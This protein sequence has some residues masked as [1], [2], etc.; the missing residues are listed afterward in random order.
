MRENF[1]V[2][3]SPQ[4]GEA[5]IAEVVDTLR[6]GWI[7]TG[8]RVAQFEEAF[9]RYIGTEHAIAVSSCT[10]GLHLSMI[11]AGLAADDEVITTPMT[12]V[13]TANAIVHTGA[14]PVFV[15][16]DR[17]T[18]LI[19]PQ[20]I[21]DA[22]TPRTRAIVPV[23]LHGRPCD[24]DA[25]TEIAE[26]HGLIVIEDA[27]HAIESVH[28]GRK[29]GT[30]GRLTCFSFYATKNMTT[31]EGG[32]VTTND[33]DLADRIK[34]YALH[35]MSRD[36]WRRF[37]DAGYRHYQVGVPGFKYNMTDLQAAIGIHQLP[38]LDAW[39][40]R[41]NRIWQWYN[42]AFGEL[43]VGLPAPDEPDVVHARHLYTLTIDRE[44]CGIDRDEFMRRLYE[45]RI[46]TGVHY[47]GAHLHAF[48]RERFGLRPEDF[49][50][51]TWI[52]ER[53][54]SIPLSPGLTDND[55]EDVIAAVTAAC[56]R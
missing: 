11:A 15:D 1:L 35:G 36:A 22:V 14:R 12:F 37:S 33:P 20:R 18:G 51:A 44:R 54:V 46:G 49:P 32:M 10:A 23:H 39:L 2:F 31:G 25:I 9:R 56:T 7:G 3:G 42:E 30:I 29:I 19:D 48:Y 8:P 55:V 53:T 24:M 45:S 16:C 27:A 52:S 34:I 5:E 40:D 21:E 38:R 47:V 26:R 17:D 43:P 41:R 50:N 28:R 13:A 6:S 4:I